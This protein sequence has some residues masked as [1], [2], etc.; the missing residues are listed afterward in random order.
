MSE[1]IYKL[2]PNRTI[3]LRGFNDLGAAAAL[4][5]ATATSFKVSG[6]FRDPA[7]FCVLS[8]YDSDNFFEHPSLKHLPD[9]N[10]DGLTLTFD[11]HYSGLRNLDSPRYPIIDWPYLD[12]IRPDGSTANIHLF[13]SPALV[14]G[15]WISATAQFTVVDGGL[16]QWDHLTLWY[17]N[18][19]LDYVVPQVET[20]YAFTP[21]RPGF[22]HS[23]TVAGTDYSYVEQTGDADITIAQRL[24]DALAAA[25]AYVTATRVFNQV[26]LRAA[27]GDGLAFEVSSTASPD[28]YT[29]YRVSKESV[30][31]ELARQCNATDWVKAGADIP[32]SAEAQGAVITFTANK[33]GLDGNALSMYATAANAQ[34]TTQEQFVQFSGG[35]S[36]ATWRVTIDFTQAKIPQIRKMWLTFAPPLSIGKA[37]ESTEWQATFSNWTLTGPEDLRSLQVAGPGSFR[38]E[39]SSSACLYTGKW[40]VEAGFYSRGYAK[41][42]K[43]AGDS[44]TIQYDASTVHDLWLGTSLY[45]D[46]GSAGV[47][48]DTGP[49]F[50]F[51]AFLQTGNDPAVI[52]RRKLASSMAP[53]SHT[54]TIQRKEDKPFYFDFLD[55]VVASDV[56]DNKPGRTNISPALDYSTDHTYKLPPARILWMFD[57]LGFA[58]P[59]N[60]YIGVF[61]WNQRTRVGATLPQATLSFTGTFQNGDQVWLTIAGTRIGKSVFAND[62]NET[63]AQHFASYVNSTFVG[64]WAAASGS[65]LTLTSHSPTRDF[66]FD[67]STSVDV[68]SGST[69]VVTVQGTLKFSDYLTKMG[70][71]AVDPAQSPALNRGAREWHADFY[72]ECKARNREVVSASSMELVLPPPAFPARYYNGD[73]VKTQVGF[74]SSWTSAQCAFN[75]AMLAYQKGV[76]ASLAG[77]MSAAGLV[78]NLQFGEYSWWY[79]KSAVDGSMALY[80]SDTQFA[81]QMA[82]GRPLA[83]FNDPDEDPMLNGGADA[84]FLRN[85]L[86]DHV[87]ALTSDLR[88]KYPNA[89]FEVLFPYDVN[90]PTPSGV[91]K[92]G[93]RLLRFINFPAEWERKQ[94]SGL[95]RLKMEGLDW[96]AVSRNLDLA[97]DVMEFPIHLG[98]PLDSIRYMLPIFNGGCPWIR[99]Y[100]L[101]K[102]LRIPVINLWAFDH[103]CIFGLPVGEPAKPAR[104]ARF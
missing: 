7:D 17:L 95:D 4:H 6:V 43:Q 58:G 80:D 14:S 25:S 81:A 37:F 2:Q 21:Q 86:R 23:I 87:A 66:Q 8:V 102:G 75:A 36:D 72:M 97:R 91:G 96:G 39:D 68:V 47:R 71:W 38:I 98:W 103:V 104:S 22:T 63:I 20:A 29:L 15:T 1:R 94:T 57:K 34:L 76:F 79:F 40:N 16:R 33:R 42:S 18:R 3:Q 19:A 13:D 83:L 24:A 85:R 26:N 55:I 28:H 74:G 93:G 54:V 5:S 77:M 35:D 61:W 62:T 65:I 82:L 10:F 41:V 45:T 99:E 46:R 84:T 50:T 11:V 89:V 73:P 49:D 59:V 30:A 90:Y 70:E 60:E 44:V 88:A 67:L 48:I 69:G 9:T 64:V 78:P 51:E 56:P 52:T 101:A 32:I 100:R 31:A 53:G 12:V 27:L 92:L